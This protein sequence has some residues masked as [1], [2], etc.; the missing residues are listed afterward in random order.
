MR[1][2]KGSKVQRHAA[3]Q[4][5]SGEVC[6]PVFVTFATSNMQAV[7]PFNRPVVAALPTKQRKAK[8]IA[9]PTYKAAFRDAMQQREHGYAAKV[10]DVQQR[11]DGTLVTQG[12]I[13]IKVK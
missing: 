6:R 1:D 7:D 12:G 11:K 8:F 4:L 13:R 9:R 2:H 3:V 5:D 10:Y